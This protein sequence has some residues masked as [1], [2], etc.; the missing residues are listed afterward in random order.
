MNNATELSIIDEHI[1]RLYEQM[2]KM[3]DADAIRA[4]RTIK[5]LEARINEIQTGRPARAW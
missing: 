2:A 1:D 3:K 4:V 5:H